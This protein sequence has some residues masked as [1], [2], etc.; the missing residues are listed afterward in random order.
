MITVDDF[1][2]KFDVFKG[3]DEDRIQSL[4]DEAYQDIPDRYEET[5]RDRLAGLSVAHQLKLSEVDTI[6]VEG[7]LR[8]IEAGETI[9]LNLVDRKQKYYKQTIYGQKYLEVIRRNVG[10]SIYVG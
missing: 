6:E 4:I 10:T 3:E 5:V 1:L 7:A 9:K 8:S 2:T